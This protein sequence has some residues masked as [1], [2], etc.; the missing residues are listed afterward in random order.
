MKFSLYTIETKDDKVTIQVPENPDKNAERMMAFAK[1]FLNIIEEKVGLDKIGSIILLHKPGQTDESQWYPFR[2]A[3]LLWKMNVI[4][5]SNAIDNLMTAVGYKTRTEAK[6]ALKECA[7]HDAD[8]IPL[9]EELKLLD[10]K[11]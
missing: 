3:P 2:V 4:G 7:G 5:T 8:L 6:K 9:I 11:G 10:E 1:Y